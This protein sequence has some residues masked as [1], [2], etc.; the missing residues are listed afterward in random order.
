[1]QL[2]DLT[3]NQNIKEAK[4]SALGGEAWKWRCRLLTWDE[5]LLGEGS[6]ALY[7][8]YVQ[9]GEKHK[10]RCQLTLVKGYT[11]SGVYQMLTEAEPN[12]RHELQE[13]IWNKSFCLKVSIFA[14]QLFHNRI[15]TKDDLVKRGI[16]QQNLNVVLRMQCCRKCELLIFGMWL[17][18][19]F[20]A[21]TLTMNEYVFC[22]P[23]K[24]E[25]S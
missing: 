22:E 21:I 2:F 15:P 11:I 23:P 16:L 9:V 1:M 20:L 19:N 12:T 18:W 13:I 25:W 24:F 4:M 10:W 3:K 6:E 7:N 8:I 14:W 5:E 17:L